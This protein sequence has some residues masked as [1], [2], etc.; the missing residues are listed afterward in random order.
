M[1]L[2]SIFLKGYER[3]RDRPALF[4][5][6]TSVSYAELYRRASA[7][8][9]ALPGMPHHVGVLDDGT[10]TP[11][12]ALLGAL[13]SGRCYIPLGAR[14]PPAR[15]LRTI[16]LAGL[17]TLVTEARAANRF[18]PVL[19]ECRDLDL[20]L[21]DSSPEEVARVAEAFPQHR[22]M[23]IDS[24]HAKLESPG[25][26]GPDT[27]AYMMFTSGTT[28]TP[29]GV[30]VSHRNVMAFV[31]AMDAFYDFGPDD[32]FVQLADLTFDLSVFPTYAAWSSGATL[33]LTPP[34]ARMM[35]ATFIDRHEFTVW[36]SVPSVAALMKAQGVLE[37]GRFPSIRHSFFCGEPLPVDLA[38]AWASAA[39]NGT[40]DN[41]YGPTETTVAVTVHRWTGAESETGSVGGVV[42]IGRC[43]PNVE[44]AVVDANLEPVPTGEVGQ[45]C[46][47]GEQVALGYW[48]DPERTDERFVSM[49]WWE[50]AGS[51][52]WYR[53][54]DLGI[55]TV[56]GTLVF[57]GREDDQTKI[58]GYRVELGEV[59]A[60]LRAAADVSIAVAVPVPVGSTNATGIVG[61]VPSPAPDEGALLARLRR[62]LP[63]YMVPAR[64][65]A[66]TIPL[67]ANRKIDRAEATRL[68]REAYGEES[69]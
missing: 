29:K 31:S 27:S 64:I 51:N 30:A 69:R 55:M 56:E 42:S 21:L 28:G 16:E 34:N 35:A 67:N 14:L 63:A 53:T 36:T 9:A 60:A 41:H 58:F 32:R 40:V 37:P 7:V 13:L 24:S 61:L 45:L 1:N 66:T 23:G 33:Y 15:T 11:Y 39:P 3:S 50:G 22:V 17:R 68:V 6:S 38:N 59:E 46:F 4:R 12:A 49:P 52:R 18:S 2:A 62:E 8:S 54:G 47:R 5:G 10:D 25:D 65:I 20:L 19:L 26:V 43:Y 57:K 44:V 48:A